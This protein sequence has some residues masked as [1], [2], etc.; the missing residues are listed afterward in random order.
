MKLLPLKAMKIERYLPKDV[1]KPFIRTFI[2]IESEGGMVSNI[3]PD[4]S[5]VIA[6]RF[7]GSV[8]ATA[9]G[10]RQVLPPSVLS[11]IRRSSRSMAY[12][13]GTA[14]LLVVFHE[15]GAAAFFREPLHELS[16]MSLPLDML[17]KNS[18]VAEMEERLAAADD[19]TQRICIIE[20]WLFSKLR[21][22]APDTLVQHAIQQI[23]LTHGAIRIKDL[24]G[25][26][27]ISQDAFEKRFRRQAG[28]SPKQF[29]SIVRFRHLIDRYSGAASLTDA[30]LSAGYFDQ[31]HFIKDFKAFTGKTPH[32]FF[33]EVVY[34]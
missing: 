11:G 18:Q 14:N 24:A 17:M 29:S 25:S 8:V 5:L 12:A 3:L 20:Q 16:D 6:F 4:T 34:W 32:D 27:Y 33:R 22:P 15:A 10:Q 30:A 1:L 7:R 23:Q 26:L 19:N 9:D 28:V 31:A 2:I 21:N 13:K